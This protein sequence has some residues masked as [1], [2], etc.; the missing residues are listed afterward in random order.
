MRAHGEDAM[1]TE[2]GPDQPQPPD[3][4]LDPDPDTDEPWT[5]HEPSDPTP[6]AP[7]PS[8]GTGDDPQPRRGI[9]SA[10]PMTPGEPLPA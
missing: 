10:A 1:S 4:P 7:N 6:V 3:S 9:G 2:P 5:P 8:P